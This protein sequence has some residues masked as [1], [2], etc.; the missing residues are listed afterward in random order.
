LT[1]IP[2]M[3]PGASAIVPSYNWHWR[4]AYPANEPCE[5]EVKS[6]PPSPVRLPVQ[7]CVFAGPVPGVTGTVPVEAKALHHRIGTVERGRNGFTYWV[8]PSTTFSATFYPVGRHG[9]TACTIRSYSGDGGHYTPVPGEPSTLPVP[10]PTDK[11]DEKTP[12]AAMAQL[13]LDTCLQ[14]RAPPAPTMF[15]TLDNDCRWMVF[16][17]LPLDTVMALREV[18]EWEQLISR[19][20]EVM[21]VDQ[22]MARVTPTVNKGKTTTYAWFLKCRATRMDFKTYAKNL[23]RALKHYVAFMYEVFHVK[24]EWFDIGAGTCFPDQLKVTNSS[25]WMW[26]LP[27]STFPLR[28]AKKRAETARVLRFL[29]GHLFQRLVSDNQLFRANHCAHEYV[30]DISTPET[31]V[32]YKYGPALPPS[33][34]PARQRIE[35]F[36]VERG[37][38]IFYG[39]PSNAHYFFDQ[40]EDPVEITVPFASCPRARLLVKLATD[41]YSVQWLAVRPVRLF[42]DVDEEWRATFMML[43]LQ[44]MSTLTRAVGAPPV[45]RQD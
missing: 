40:Y 10:A 8:D 30:M 6:A 19:S 13:S 2:S 23:H 16:S 38:L 18:S 26:D 14:F 37:L 21:Q 43:C 1:M 5:E 35:R 3:I 25:H 33:G 15:D 32:R 31:C 20:Y 27:E 4:A 42:A 24:S 39:A 36:F 41:D 11:D 29:H 44:P 34:T 45:F 17:F 12:T 9:A 22:V 7:D 28:H